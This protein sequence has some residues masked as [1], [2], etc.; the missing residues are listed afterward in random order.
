MDYEPIIF[1]AAIAVLIIG[2]LILHSIAELISAKAAYY[3]ELTNE[4]KAKR[5]QKDKDEPAEPVDAT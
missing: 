2:V 1:F 3:Q 5:K 4:I